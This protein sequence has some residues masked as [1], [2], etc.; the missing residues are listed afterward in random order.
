MHILKFGGTS[1]GDSSRIL[2]VFNL[3]IERSRIT[4][5]GV[6]V[7]AISGITNY[8][9]DS[10]E[11]ALNGTD[12]MQLIAPFK[13]QHE[14]II[15]HLAEQKPTLNQH[16]LRQYL[17]NSCQKYAALLQ[18]IQLLSACPDPVYAQIISLG[19]CLL[20]R[21][22]YGLLLTEMSDVA[23]L[24]GGDYIKTKGSVRDGMPMMEEIE[25]RFAKFR[26]R[27]PQILLMAGFMASNMEG[28]PTVLGRNG[29][30]YSAAL[31]AVGLQAE[32]CE[33]WT[34]V[35]GI[36]TADPRLVPDAQVISEM[37]YGEAMELSFYGAKILHPKTIAPLTAHHIPVWIRNSLNPSVPGTKIH[38]LVKENTHLVQGISCLAPI[39]LINILGPGMKGV[40]GIAARIFLAVS[41]CN[42]SIVLIT[43]SSSEYSICFCVAEK[44]ANQ[45]KEV[46]QDEFS[47]EIS[48][49]YIENIEVLSNHAIICIVGDQMRLRRGIAGKFFGALASADINVVAISQGSSERSISAVIDGKDMIDAMN[50]THRFFFRTLHS[51]DVFLLGP[52]AVGKELLEQI[53]LRQEELINQNIDLRVCGIA[54]SNRMLLSKTS[55]ALENWQEQLNISYIKTNLPALFEHVRNEKLLNAVLVDC[56]SSENIA[57]A[58]PEIFKARFHIVTANKKAN[59][60]NFQFYKKLRK[61]ANEHFRR[62]S[63]ETNVGAGLPIIDTLQNMIKSGDQLINFSGILSGSLSFIFGLL[64]EGILFSEA[65]KIAKDKN[66]TEPDPRDDLSGFDV[67]R[68]LLILHREIGGQLEL[69]DIKITPLIPNNFDMTGSVVDF[70]TNIKNLDA[71]FSDWMQRLREN[72][73]VL[74]YVGEMSADQCRVGIVEIAADHPLMPVKGGENAFVFLTRRYSPIPL[75]V[76]GYGAGPEVTAAGVFSDIL[77]SADDTMLAVNGPYCH[78]AGAVN[79]EN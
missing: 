70:L 1:L 16:D 58:Y 38:D 68:K 36:Y 45:V 24:D 59:T 55:I 62:F 19:E 13:I 14:E 42:I 53:R 12:I 69:E 75:V 17:D 79:E 30:D 56:T 4:R 22:L 6:I 33:I 54:N 65:V 49:Q 63:Y 51:V 37:S 67:A 73:K 10:I 77:C 57:E 74:R 48:A 76:R 26:Q 18:G 3:I 35:D 23:L 71:Y 20:V 72:N 5:V 39:A 29:S 50:M 11:K 7:S 60:K 66:F 40:P 25:R 61:V 31:M 47:L 8:L 27:S 34:D 52:G 28:Q 32:C 44:D 9:S 15:L 78:Y 2:N 46:L 21:I 41:R 43:Q 64:E